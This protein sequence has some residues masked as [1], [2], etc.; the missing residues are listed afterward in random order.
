[1]KLHK[2]W[3]EFIECL[4]AAGVRYV[5][6]GGIAVGFHGY[7]RMTGDIDFFVEP[8]PENAR[9]ILGVLSRFGFTDIGVSES[10]L[11]GPDQVVQ[12]GR[13]PVRIDLMTSVDQV[14]FDEAWASRVASALDGVTVSFISRDLLLRNKKATG[15][16]RDRG[17]YDELTGAT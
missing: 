3:R 12:L 11:S 10:D 13:P 16:T 1:M 9:R 4:N 17:D 7:P 2:D 6:V 15:R 8:T 14:S 5:V